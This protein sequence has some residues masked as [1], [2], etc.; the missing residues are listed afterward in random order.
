MVVPDLLVAQFLPFAA[1]V[2]TYPDRRDSEVVFAYPA[3]D[4]EGGQAA[5]R[6]CL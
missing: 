4:G 5:G 3:A 1:G 2:S 6:C